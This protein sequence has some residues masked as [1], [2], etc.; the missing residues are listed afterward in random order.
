MVRVTGPALSIDA[1]GSVAKTLTFAKWKGRN[2]AR[3]RVIPDNPKSASQVGVRC[4]LGFLAALWASLTAGEQASWEEDAEE[5]QIS[6]FNQYVSV[7]LV[8][9]QIFDAP[10]KE[11]P[12]AEASTPLTVSDMTLTGGDGNALVQLTPSA[13]TAIWGF[14]ICRDTAEITAPNWTNAVHIL[15][16]D[17]INQ[18]QWTD[19]PIAPGTYHYRAAVINEDGI[20]GEFIADD[21]VVVT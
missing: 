19:S 1:S 2:Y 6:A 3:Q 11:F 12:A 16:A 4:M 15:E 10:T 21:T 5:R 20:M 13:A 8:R 18:V 17:G 9:W 14:V 7:N